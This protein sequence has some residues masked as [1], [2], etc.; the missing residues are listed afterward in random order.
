MMAVKSI[1]NIGAHPEQDIRLIVEVEPGESKIFLD[2]I[3]LLDH[4][5][6][7]AR[8]ERESRIAKVQALS[9]SKAPASIGVIGGLGLAQAATRC[10]PK[11]VQ[12]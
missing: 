2:L 9:A 4:E 6:Y 12:S 5:W 10:P 8:S 7:V 11:D 3:H 1:G